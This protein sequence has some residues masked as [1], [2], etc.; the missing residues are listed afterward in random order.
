ME[1]VYY[2]RNVFRQKY[3]CCRFSI[4]LSSLQIYSHIV[5]T[6]DLLSHCPRCRF[7]LLTATSPLTE[8]KSKNIET[9]KA[10][11]SVAH[12][13]GNY[14]GHTWLEV[15][16]LT[17][18]PVAA[19]IRMSACICFLQVLRCISQL[20]LAQLIGTGVKSYNMQNGGKVK[21]KRGLSG[22][23]IEAFDPESTYLC[24]FGDELSGRHS[25]IVTARMYFRR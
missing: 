23:P 2:A 16:S 8:M 13:D 19:T 15:M 17:Q 25:V 11:I 22:H 5:L 7:T 24:L 1:Y 6:A 14:L 10:L 20:E 18:P 4:T 3:P 9:I 21:D 12:T